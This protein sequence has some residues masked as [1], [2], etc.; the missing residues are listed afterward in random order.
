MVNVRKVPK[1]PPDIAV[2]LNLLRTAGDF[3]KLATEILHLYR[4]GNYSYNSIG[5]AVGMTPQR[6]RQLAM[7]ADRA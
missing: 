6:V 1:L 4:D 2:E 7:K 3:T 5:A